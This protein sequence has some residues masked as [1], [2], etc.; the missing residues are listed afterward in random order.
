MDIDR[1]RQILE[2]TN[3]I[4]V[5]YDGKPVWIEEVFESSA[6]ARVHLEH[7]PSDQMHVKVSELQE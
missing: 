7:K 1:A 2:S 6:T 3:K 5:K 4:N